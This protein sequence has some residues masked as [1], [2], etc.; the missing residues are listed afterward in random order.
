[1]RKVTATALKN[2]LGSVLAAAALE[3]VAIERHGRV[4]AYLIPNQ[5]T[6]NVRKSKSA[7]AARKQPWKRRD[8]ERLVELCASKDFRPSR[9]MRAGDPRT[10]AGIVTM[11]A[12][13]KEFDRSR[14]LALAER[15]H[16]GS[17]T[18]AEFG[19]WLAHTPV[20]AARLLPMIEARRRTRA[21]G[22]G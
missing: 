22:R 5:Q 18:P 3:P 2:R 19:R 7:P 10:L 21:Q 20:Q 4:V 13:H 12:S 6:E 17:T 14:M 11:L 16:P 9:W 15:L 8:E 1:M